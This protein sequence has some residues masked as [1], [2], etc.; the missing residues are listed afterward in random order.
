MLRVFTTGLLALCLAAGAAGARAAAPVTGGDGPKK[1]ESHLWAQAR[2]AG[3][4]PVPV[5][6]QLA[7]PAADVE[8]LMARH[9]GKVQAKFGFVGAFRTEVPAAVLTR[10]AADPAVRFISLDAP[11]RYNALDT[12][13]LRTIYDQLIGAPQAWNTQGLT[14]KGVSVAVLDT[15]VNPHEDIKDHLTIIK[16]NS[17]ALRFD[18]DNGHGTHVAGI[19]AGRAASGQYIGVAPEAQIIGIKIADDTGKSSEGD[20][21]RGLQWI[22]DNRTKYNIRVVNVSVS[23]S[24]PISYVDSAIDA[25]VEQLWRAGVVV[26]VAA[27]NRG[28]EPDAVQ[29]PPANDPF[30]ITVGA[31]DDAGTLTKADDSL[32]FFSSVGVTQDGFAK[33]EIIAPGR[34]VVSLLSKPDATLAL[35]FPDRVTDT[36]YIR[37]SGTSMAAP[38]VAGTAA[39][40]LQRYPNLTPDQVK[41]ALITSAQ[42]YSSQPAG[43]APALDV[44]AALALLGAGSPGTANLGLDWNKGMDL[45]SGAIQWSTAY[46]ENAYW[47]SAY[48]DNADYELSDFD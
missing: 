35:R 47:E 37:L 30:A 17:R 32:A 22:Y 12:T 10:L 3:G 48:S 44:N 19:I 28:P 38:V 29:Y 2:A 15:G 31:L 40:L 16:S 23:G 14:G 4:K 43:T 34:K 8:G 20:L 21:L 41:W 6:V 36:K 9:G 7:D 5:I 33:P 39:L 1:V 18:D 46:W 45:A 42:P 25:G 11:L 13:Q 26:V 27:G 24:V